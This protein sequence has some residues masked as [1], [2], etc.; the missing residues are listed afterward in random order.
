MT[1]GIWTQVDE[2]WAAAYLRA[3]VELSRSGSMIVVD[4]VVRGGAVVDADSTDRSVLGTRAL[5]DALAAEPRLDATA[6]QTVGDKG[7]DG[8]VLALVR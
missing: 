1:E 6:V 2:Y 5:A 8:F 7:Y 4:D 3:A